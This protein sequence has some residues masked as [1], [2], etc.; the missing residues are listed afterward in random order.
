[1]W[2]RVKVRSSC[3]SSLLGTP[4]FPRLSFR[5]LLQL[6][7]VRIYE[8]WWIIPR[9]FSIMKACSPRERTGPYHYSETLS[10]IGED[11]FSPFYL[12]LSPR[13]FCL[14]WGKGGKNIVNGVEGFREI[15]WEHRGQGEGERERK[16]RFHQKRNSNSCV[17]L[18]SETKSDV[19]C[20]LAPLRC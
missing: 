17:G 19:E 9:T 1:M 5:G 15:D 10:Q 11:N 16:I 18:S 2:T 20:S 6:P 7:I 8:K 13:P 3:R 14:S 4:R 12:P